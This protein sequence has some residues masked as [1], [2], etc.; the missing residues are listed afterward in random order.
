MFSSRPLV[1][2]ST[3]RTLAPFASNW[4]AMVDPINEEPPVMSTLR[5]DQNPFP[6]VM[7]DLPPRLLAQKFETVSLYHMTLPALGICG[8][9][10]LIVQGLPRGCLRPRPP[11]WDRPDR[12]QC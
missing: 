5:P 8:P 12:R 1:R 3:T 6:L 11:P 9:C 4:S 10:A 7:P 2:S